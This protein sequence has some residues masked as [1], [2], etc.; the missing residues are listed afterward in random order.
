[1]TTPWLSVVTVVKDDP[2]GLARTLGSLSAQDLTEVEWVVVDSS[3][4]TNAVSALL[5]GFEGL[6]T[7]TWTPPQGVY[8]AMNSAIDSATGTLL[9]FAN[10]GDEF[11]RSDVL[12]RARPMLRERVWGFGPVEIVERDGRRVF[13]PGWDYATEAG[14]GF[15]RGLFPAHQ[16]TFVLRSTL[17]DLGGFDTSYAVAADYAMALRLSQV[18][19]PVLLPF[20]VARFHEGGISTQRW[21]D[22]FKEFH[23]AR[24][25]ILLPRGN[26]RWQEELDTRIHWASV[27]FSREVRP[28]LLRGRR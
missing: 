5:G 23:R 20:V 24:K 6:V 4:D 26:D 2:E 11:F 16:G 28:R 22:S 19:D 15:S 10:A 21:Q 3:A 9:H 25:Q 13:T 27:W 12:Q 17:R 18:A 1:M 8:P 14:R 7:Y